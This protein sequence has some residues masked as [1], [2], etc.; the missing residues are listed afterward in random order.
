MRSGDRLGRKNLGHLPCTCRD[1]VCPPAQKAHKLL[2]V[3]MH[4]VHVGNETAISRQDFHTAVYLEFG[5][6]VNSNNLH[7]CVSPSLITRVKVS[8]SIIM[9]M[10]YCRSG[11]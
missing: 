10:D 5:F 6:A 7:C 9:N 8:L 1:R 3:G 4:A 11:Q 2:S